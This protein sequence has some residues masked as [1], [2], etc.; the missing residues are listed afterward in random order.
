MVRHV[1]FQYPSVEK[2]MHMGGDERNMCRPK[3]MEGVK[4]FLVFAP[5]IGVNFKTAGDYLY[6]ICSSSRLLTPFM[7][8]DGGH[9]L[10]KQWWSI[11]RVC[12]QYYSIGEPL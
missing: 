3:A 10:T 6:T 4:V 9:Q 1:E 2:S 12:H 5:F 8:I 11:L 7:L